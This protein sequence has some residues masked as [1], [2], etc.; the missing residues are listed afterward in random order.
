LQTPTQQP[1]QQPKPIPQTP[2]SVPQNI[3]MKP[4]IHF[5][6][7]NPKP[8]TR[9]PKELIKSTN[10]SH[11]K[12][13]LSTVPTTNI[14]VPKLGESSLGIV[15]FKI[16]EYASWFDITKIHE[17][18]RNIFSEYFDNSSSLRTEKIYKEYRDFMIFAYQQNPQNY[19]TQ[20]ACRRNLAGDVGSI[21]RIHSFLEHWGLI[22]FLVV[23]EMAIIHNI[24][25]VK[26]TIFN[27]KK[28]N[29]IKRKS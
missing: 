17:I 29:R 15:Q 8:V 13:T 18:E 3:T 25:D 10:I 26:D 27:E 12:P 21:L 16:P 9:Y 11:I 1:Q 22:N 7:Q 23:P 20:T 2:N 6:N 4:P 24:S 14:V 28:N 5:N 19:L